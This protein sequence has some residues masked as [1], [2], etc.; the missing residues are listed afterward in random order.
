MR[1]FIK[2]LRNYAT[3]KGRARRAEYWYYTLFL[4]LTL[5]AVM[6]LATICFGK[7]AGMIAYYLCALALFMPSLAVTVRRLHDINRSGKLL[8]WLYG[9]F[10]LAGLFIILISAENPTAAM[11]F[12]ALPGIAALG[13]G[14]YLLVLF[15]TAGTRGE[16]IYGQDPKRTGDEVRI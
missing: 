12:Y 1:W 2:C 11:M 10:I 14:V 4:A 3:F 16:N 5:T 6:L 8:I 13:I 9:G 15:C 7:A